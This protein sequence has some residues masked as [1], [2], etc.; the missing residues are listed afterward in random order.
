M[1]SN[2]SL[3]CSL[4]ADAIDLLAT[5]HAVQQVC[6][7]GGSAHC[8]PRVPFEHYST[9]RFRFW[10]L[11]LEGPLSMVARSSKTSI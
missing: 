4:A 8:S 6:S 7:H 9:L 1:N 2:C 10:H 11:G 3:H 5:R